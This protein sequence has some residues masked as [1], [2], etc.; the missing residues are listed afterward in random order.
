MILSAWLIL[1]GCGG[2]SRGL[3]REQDGDYRQEIRA[4]S[5]KLSFEDVS[6]IPSAANSSQEPEFYIIRI[7]AEAENQNNEEVT[8]TGDWQP[9]LQTAAGKK[10]R[11]YF[12]A[13]DP[14]PRLLPKEKT[15]VIFSFRAQ[16]PEVQEALELR[17]RGQ[18]KT[19]KKEGL[20]ALDRTGERTFTSPDWG[21]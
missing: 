2:D 10:L 18:N 16:P 9:E 20:G 3:P 12:G 8:F 6:L 11:S 14:E 19:V 7:R 1:A 5:V 21:G 13:F 17:I 4:D 15:T